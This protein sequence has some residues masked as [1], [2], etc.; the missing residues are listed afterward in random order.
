VGRGMHFFLPYRL[1]RPPSSS[2]SLSR[3]YH[4]S[5]RSRITT[6]TIKTTKT[7]T[8]RTM[9]I[10]DGE[11]SSTLSNDD[12]GYNNSGRWTRLTRVTRRLFRTMTTTESRNSRPSWRWEAVPL[13][14]EDGE[15]DGDDEEDDEDDDEEE[16]K[17]DDSTEMKETMETTDNDDDQEKKRDNDN[18][19]SGVDDGSNNVKETMEETDNNNDDNQ[20]DDE[21]KEMMETTD[22]KDNGQEKKKDNDNDDSG[23]E[24]GSNEVKAT[25][26]E[27][28]NNID[29]QDDDEMKEM[30][31][32]T[33]NND[34]QEEKKYN[35]NDDSGVEDG[36]N[37]VEETMEET[38]N[39]NNDDDNDG[40][41]G[42]RTRFKS[43]VNG[44]KKRKSNKKNDDGS[45][46]T[47]TEEVV[48]GLKR[49]KPNKYND[50]G[51]V[52]AT[53]EVVNNVGQEQKQQQGSE[54]LPSL[55][56]DIRAEG[57]SGS[58]KRGNATNDTAIDNAAAGGGDAAG[59]DGPMKDDTTNTVE[60]GTANNDSEEKTIEAIPSPLPPQPT[61]SS[62]DNTTNTVE[63]GIANNDSEKKTVEAIPSPLPPQLA[64]SSSD[65][66]TN[67]VEAIPSPLPPQP[68]SFSSD[69]FRFSNSRM[70]RIFLVQRIMS[71]TLPIL[72]PLIIV[73]IEPF[74]GFAENIDGGI[75]GVNFNPSAK[76]PKIPRSGLPRTS[77]IFLRDTFSR[78]DDENNGGESRERNSVSGGGGVMI[79]E[80]GNNGN[81]GNNV[82]R[83]EG[84][85]PFRD[86]DASSSHSNDQR[87]EEEE[88]EDGI[89]QS[90]S[91]NILLAEEQKDDYD[92]M[93]TPQ[94]LSPPPT[95]G[96]RGRREYRSNAMGY[97]ADAVESVGPA[98]VRIDTEI[99]LVQRQ[100]YRVQLDGD[101]NSDKP[102][103]PSPRIRDNDR[104]SE[105]DI[106][107]DDE[108]KGVLETIPE[109]MKFIQQGQGSGI[110]YTTDGLVLTNAHVVQGASRVMVTLTDGRRFGAVVKGTD[111][112]VDIAV[113]KITQEDKG[114]GEGEVVVGGGDGYD[115][116]GGSH[117]SNSGEFT[118]TQPSSPSTSSLNNNQKSKSLPTAT[119]GNSDNIQIGQFV[120]AV[121]SPGGLDNTV[122]MGIISGLKRSPEAIGLTNKKVDFIQTDAAI[123]PGNSGG[124]LVDVED[125]TVI[126]INTCIRANMEGTSFAVPINKVKAIVEDL[127]VGKHI[128]HG[129]VGVSMVTLTPNLARQN[130]ADPNSPN[131][132]V[133]EIDGAVITKVYPH[134]PA[135]V[136]GLC[137]LDVVIEIGGQRVFRADE[138]QR[139]I[140]GAAVG[141]DLTVKVIRNDKEI[142]M[143]IRPEDLGRKLRRIKEHK[144]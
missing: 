66:T 36:S 74:V 8:A 37:N 86:V 71:L 20:D 7:T 26:E 78:G 123:N 58:V 109:Q 101:D 99:E 124:P 116:G 43:F 40:T 14:I 13:E 77:R 63:E 57:A 17:E 39:N 54:L 21:M 49:T 51:A 15:E 31:E 24:D 76:L 87:S 137:R 80:D 97:V 59:D 81:N 33:D 106:T 62:S 50:D 35:D 38:D 110:I 3:G 25:M 30:M 16:E 115:G 29:D 67:T 142:T 95:P 118:E 136:G 32:T 140:D 46:S 5:I 112:I 45:I 34:G 23:V 129:Y 89:E 70:V 28:D 108:E 126:G 44:L 18:D 139:M 132:H 9:V 144:R 105:D 73:S 27:T 6:P 98:V 2:L 88:E 55:R 94:Q 133:P 12:D 72:V 64:S 69:N 104:S 84:V 117:G 102:S 61:S 42:K 90:P 103:L 138:A 120:L 130:N 127:A 119:L 125:G 141:K 48:K 22:N 107:G 11:I 47:A 121:G 75:T 83:E 92:D 96:G 56:T 100:R 60:E 85:T 65:N 135:E 19:D 111:E 143:S 53:T 122:T 4:P 68:A 79:K 41:L 131:G 134:T 113:L 52:S 128:D 82:E 114:K 10:I 1:R 93:L 91:E